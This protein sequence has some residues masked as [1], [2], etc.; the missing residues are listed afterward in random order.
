MLFGV[1]SSCSNPKKEVVFHYSNGRVIKDS[2]NIRLLTRQLL[3]QVPEFDSTKSQTIQTFLD[4]KMERSVNRYIGTNPKREVSGMIILENQSG[5]VVYWKNTEELSVYSQRFQTMKMYG[6]LLSFEE[7]VKLTDHYSW[8]GKYSKRKYDST[9]ARL[10][11]MSAPSLEY[12]YPFDDYSCSQWSSFL[13][14]LNVSENERD[15]ADGEIYPR[16]YFRTSLFDLVKTVALIHQNGFTSAHNLFGE[17]KSP[18]G[19]SLHIPVLV[20]GKVL[21]TETCLAAKKVLKRDP[22]DLIEFSYP[23]FYYAHGEIRNGMVLS[24]KNYTVGF[25]S[26][27][28]SGSNGFVTK[29]IY[30]LAS[31]LENSR[32]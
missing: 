2:T 4:P 16:Y 1:I 5:N 30:G 26:A 27:S 25:L 3:A 13:Q 17:I 15:C 32:H 21:K 29:E 12:R 31:L 9:V 7:G 22:F 19:K 11:R 8:I 24:T 14:K 10:Y 23:I 18:E 20:K 28:K 6:M